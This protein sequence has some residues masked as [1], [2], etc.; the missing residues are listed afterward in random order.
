MKKIWVTFSG[1]GYGLKRV[2]KK[3]LWFKLGYNRWK[4]WEIPEKVIVLIFEKKRLLL[5][6]KKEVLGNAREELY[7]LRYPDVYKGKGIKLSGKEIRQ[8]AGKK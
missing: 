7:S 8:K 3:R 6:G 2:G 4:Y 1:R 5:I